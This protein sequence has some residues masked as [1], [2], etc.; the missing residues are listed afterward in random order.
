GDAGRAFRLWRESDSARARARSYDLAIPPPP[1]SNVIDYEARAH[2][3]GIHLFPR[4]NW[5]VVISLS[6]LFLGLGAAP[7]AGPVRIAFALLGLLI[8]L[9]GVAGWVLVE[10]FRIYQSSASGDAPADAPEVGH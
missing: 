7:F 3:L 9:T 10:D 1:A 6:F 8:L 2:Q 4:S 5:P